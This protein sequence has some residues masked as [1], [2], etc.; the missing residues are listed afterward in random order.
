[1]HS[2][3][4]SFFP[5]AYEGGE[6]Y[7]LWNYCWF[8]NEEDKTDESEGG[9]RGADKLTSDR[10]V[11]VRKRSDDYGLANAN[12]FTYNTMAGNGSGF[13]TSAN[14]YME[15]RYAE[16]LLNLA[17]SACGIDE[18]GEAWNLLKDIRA[19]V[20]PAD[21][22]ADNYG[23]AMSGSQAE[24]FAAILYERQ[25]ELAYEGKRF[26]DMRRWMLF[27][28]GA[29][30]ESLNPSWA[31]SGWG[32]NTCTYL[33]VTSA[34]DQAR[35]NG[36]KHR[37]I[38]YVTDGTGGNSDDADPLLDVARPA[39]LTLDEDFHY[40]LE[41]G[42]YADANVRAVA[43]FYHTYLTR[44]DLPTDEYDNGQYSTFRPEYY[45]IGL[46]QSAQS[47]NS[48]LLQNIGWH[49]NITGGDGT[50]DPVAE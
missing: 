13:K 17:E 21:M 29:G 48:T 24:T 6:D 8:E 9:V 7:V 37:I 42:E 2:S 40:S 16:V 49:D 50:F 12:L 3:T 10:G 43:E 41:H 45:F 47:N 22:E 1:M 25:I 33:G 30:Q 27:D 36:S 26:D 4:T 39:G 44:K 15:I 31:L 32:G 23:L 19:R 5:D 20:Y 11:Y 34:N 38:L 46:R 14:P 28:G 18:T 35:A